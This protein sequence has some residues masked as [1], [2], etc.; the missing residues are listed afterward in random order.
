MQSIVSEVRE[1]GDAAVRRLTEKFDGV[2]L[3]DLRVPERMLEKAWNACDPLLREALS[4][5]IERIAAYHRAQAGQRPEPWAI[6][7]E[8]ASVGEDVQP[9]LRVG[10]YVPGG[11]AA[12][13][14][15]VL[16]TTIPAQEAGVEEIALCVPPGP[17]GKPHATTMA[18]AWGVGINEVYAVGGAQA[19]AALAYGTES[20][21]RVEKIVGPGS[22]WV[23]LAKH[24]VAMDVGVDGFAGP[25]EIVIVAAE[26]ANPLYV[27]ADLIAQ[28][29]HDPL[30]TCMLITWSPSLV[31]EV[32]SI[33]GTEVPAASRRE[34]IE[35]ALRNQG[36]AVL[37]DDLEHAAAAANAFAPE[38]LELLVPDARQAL[39]QPPK[40]GAVFFGEYS[41]VALGDYLAGTNHVLPTGG[42]ARFASP[43][44]VS[45]F[46]RWTALVVFERDGLA[47]LAPAL[48]AIAREEG[49]PAHARAVDVRLT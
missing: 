16:M 45:D 8:R 17:D 23:T 37:V 47:E 27:A 36:Y 9:L 35:S 48:R 40:A 6:G 10:C 7:T 15:S 33:L 28:A 20:V 19:I 24:E 22:L 42:T 44:R 21:R 18:A 46:L 38:H 34:T 26:D 12:Y 41:P 2:S 4:T 5:A 3:R 31:D 1:G 43:L 11:R 13:P 30:A 29:E 14:S 32:N 25:T 39:P 49:L